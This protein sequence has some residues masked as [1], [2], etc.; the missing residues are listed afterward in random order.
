MKQRL[1]LL[2]ALIAIIL[3]IWAQETSE[4]DSLYSQVESMPR[5]RERLGKLAE[6]V[7][8]T[9]QMPQG[10]NYSR[11]LYTEAAQQQNDT[12]M[13]TAT[14]YI[15]SSHYTFSDNEI[16][17]DSIRHWAGIGLPLAKKCQLWRYYFEQKRILTNAY[18]FMDRFE[19]A[20]EEARDMAKEAER[21]GNESGLGQAYLCMGMAYQ[22]S[23][24]WKEVREMYL[25]AHEISS[26]SNDPYLNLSVLLQLIDYLYFTNHF[27]EILIYTPEVSTLV[28]QFIEA[29]PY[30]ESTLS[31]TLMLIETYNI[32]CYSRMGELQKAKERLPIAQ[33]YH[34]MM[35][36]KS[37]DK[38]Y[39]E[40]LRDYYLGTKQFNQAI[41][42]GDS[43]QKVIE[44]NGL[45]TD[46]RIF[47]LQRQGDIYYTMGDYDKALTLYCQ[48]KQLRD[49]INQVISDR[50]MLE[51]KEMFAMD[52]L[53]LEEAKAKQRIRWVVASI[54]LLIAL[55]IYLLWR[56]NYHL[57]QELRMHTEC[58]AKA[59]KTT[60]EANEQKRR[61]LA[62][63]SHAIRVP[64]HS[65]VGFSQLLSTDETLTDEERLEFGEIV[66]F[67]T[68]QL[69]F[70]VNSVLD[71]S[72]LEANMT[73]WQMVDY[74]LVQL[75]HDAAGSVKIN[76]PQVSVNLDLQCESWPIHADTGRL[77]Q[78]FV[79]LMAGTVTTPHP[80]RET[81][82]VIL[83]SDDQTLTLK[84]EGSP[85]AD[86]NRENQESALRH[87]INRLTLEYFGGSYKVDFD[88][89]L[90]TVVFQKGKEKV[91]T[92]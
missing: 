84:I 67:N 23:K 83:L 28:E 48:S 32:A 42:Y 65:V 51:I 10:I 61:F 89:R 66:R 80:E 49:S 70:L 4:E 22:G 13:V 37:Y 44:E 5:G 25:K 8:L 27:S 59:V 34:Q 55:L 45:Q 2:L 87:S 88:L 85:L 90:I 7:R 71:L 63:M 18:I 62:T 9:Q 47:H 86:A 41:A 6:L 58:T 17:L 72:R 54:S 52:R 53:E 21:L 50:Q 30:Y 77:M 56:R 46:D 82:K 91:L 69:M 33:K 57:N 81:V 11:Q 78:V 92:N 40:A 74:D 3:P 15:C 12:M 24:R 76:T 1:I 29:N 60:Q 43:V 16:G 14:T 73:K 79:S 26:K 75:V 19:Y 36:V 68:E 64:L 31:N 39:F 35:T 20:I 38:F